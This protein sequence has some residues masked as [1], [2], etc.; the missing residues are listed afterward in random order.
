M[1]PC[2]W[3]VIEVVALWLPDKLKPAKSADMTH[4]QWTALWWARAL[5]QLTVQASS[6]KETLS[7]EALLCEFLDANRVSMEDGCRTGYEYDSSL[8]ND[9]RNNHPLMR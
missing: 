6:G 5:S 1:F 9:V 7:V 3:V 2:D 4:A 8:W